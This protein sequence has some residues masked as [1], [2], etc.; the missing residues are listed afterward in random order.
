MIPTRIVNDM[1]MMKI[2]IKFDEVK[3]NSGLKPEDIK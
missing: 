1:G 2:D 3:V